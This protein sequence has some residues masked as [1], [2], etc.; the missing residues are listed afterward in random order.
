MGAQGR[1]RL[2]VVRRSVFR[3]PLPAPLRHRIGRLFVP[4]P[5]RRGRPAL[6]ACV[7]LDT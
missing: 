3:V 1:R 5:R 2:G 4:P 6:D 7:P